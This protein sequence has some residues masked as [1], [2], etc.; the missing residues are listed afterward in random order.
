MTMI[1]YHLIEEEVRKKESGVAHQEQIGPEPA[2]DGLHYQRSCST[3]PTEVESK[4]RASPD[5]E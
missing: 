2:S 5:R 1:D 4:C 3:P